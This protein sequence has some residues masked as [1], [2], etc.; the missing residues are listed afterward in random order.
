MRGPQRG[1]QGDGGTVVIDGLIMAAAWW[2][3]DGT[4]RRQEAI[5][6]ARE[7]A[8]ELEAARRQLAGH[9]AE[10]AAATEAAAAARAELEDALRDDPTVEVQDRDELIRRVAALPP[11]Q[12]AVIVL[13]YFEGHTYDEIAE[14]ALRRIQFAAGAPQFT[15]RHLQVAAGVVAVSAVGSGAAAARTVP[16]NDRPSTSSRTPLVPG[17]GTADADGIW[18]TSWGAGG[19]VALLVEDL[20]HR[21]PQ[22]TAR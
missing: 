17:S 11:R 3:G 5:E 6:A 19:L 7:R 21:P 9:A 18:D 10:L 22:S 2:L 4:R 13:R 14:L 12:R 8:A 15:N 16:S 1:R 20:G